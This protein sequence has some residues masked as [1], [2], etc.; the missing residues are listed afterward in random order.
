MERVFWYFQGNPTVD[1]PKESEVE[2][3]NVFLDLG[4]HGGQ[5]LHRFKS[6]LGFDET[7]DI[8]HF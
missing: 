4:T 3:T 1:I 8:H 6:I 2:K 5:G 7:W